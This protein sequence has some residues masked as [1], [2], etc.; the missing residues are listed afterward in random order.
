MAEKPIESAKM[1]IVGGPVGIFRHTLD[2]KKRLTIPSECRAAMG[3][4]EYVYVYPHMTLEC[5]NLISPQEMG[6]LM[7]K[8]DRASIFD[9]EA[10][11]VRSAFGESAQMIKVD[12]AGRIRINDE[13][14]DF[15]G[16]TGK[17]TL[18][19]A[20]RNIEVWASEKLPAESRKIDV[21]AAREAMRKLM[22]MK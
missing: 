11:A 6:K 16:I 2:P 3:N 17:V 5:L 8:L 19:G 18:K 20:V 12:T 4:P 1:E 14:M 13:L 7:E 21:A 22:A 15:A 9:P 10:A